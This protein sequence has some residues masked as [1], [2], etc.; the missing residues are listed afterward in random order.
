M[1][2]PQTDETRDREPASTLCHMAREDQPN[3]KNEELV[4]VKT[5]GECTDK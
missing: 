3:W 4:T 5:K 1:L 2:A